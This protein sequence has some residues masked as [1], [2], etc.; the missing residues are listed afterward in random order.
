MKKPKKLDEKYYGIK[1]NNHLYIYEPIFCSHWHI[2]I[3]KDPTE[4]VKKHRKFVGKKDDLVVDKTMDGYCEMLR[5]GTSIV[6]YIYLRKYEPDTVAHEVLHG[7]HFV[8]CD[9]ELKLTD[10]TQEIYCYFQEFIMREIL[11]YKKK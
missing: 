10:E 5:C 11:H 9:R 3:D 4:F 7:T 2:F 6:N 1:I 8:L